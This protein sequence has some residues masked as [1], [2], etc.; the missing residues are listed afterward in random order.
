MLIQH[1]FLTVV[2]IGDRASDLLMIPKAK[3]RWL[4]A[5]S[6][7]FIMLALRLFGSC[8]LL[9]RF[10]SRRLTSARVF[11]SPSLQP[12]KAPSI[13]S[14]PLL[15]VLH[16]KRSQVATR[17]QP[18]EPMQKTAVHPIHFTASLQSRA[19]TSTVRR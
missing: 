9:K 5:A 4:F 1:R 2:G 3:A 18:P 16:T 7:V 15:L 8:L 19:S 14:S 11:L 13:L 12:T 6:V 10:D 17:M